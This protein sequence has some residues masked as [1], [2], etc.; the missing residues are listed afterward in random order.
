MLMGLLDTLKGAWKAVTKWFSNDDNEVVSPTNQSQEDWTRKTVTVNTPT[1]NDV[2][3]ELNNE[4]QNQPIVN[5]NPLWQYNDSVQAKQDADRIGNQEMPDPVTETWFL[6]NTSDLITWD[7][8]KAIAK[9]QKDKEKSWFERNIVD[10]VTWFAKWIWDTVDSLSA[11]SDYDANKKDMAMYYDKDSW[12]VYYLDLNTSHWL[13]DWDTG[14]Y[15]WAER[16]FNQAMSEYQ[17]DISNAAS[18][19]ERATALLNFYSKAKDLFR[20]RADD[21]YS[22]WWLFTW[23][24]WKRLGRRK[25]Q[26][27]EETLEKLANNKWV[28]KAWKYVPTFDEFVDY[29]WT[30]Q[31][32]NDIQQ[33]IFGNYW[34]DVEDEEKIDLSQSAQNA[35]KEGFYNTAM[36]WVLDTAK[37]YLNEQDVTNAVLLSADWVTS[38]QNR[39]YNIVAQVYKQEQIVLAKPE[40]ERDDWDKKL[41]EAAN[42]LREMEEEY[43]WDLGNVIR[44]NIKYWS[45]DWVLVDNIDVFEWGKTL[46]QALTENIK[47]TA[48]W[49]WWM[50]ESAIDVFQEVA[51]KALY[52]YNKEK[53]WAWAHMQRAWDLAW[54]FLSELWQQTAFW[55]MAARNVL[56]DVATLNWE[57]LENKFTWKESLTK[58]WNYMDNDNTIGRLL[59]TDKWNNTRTIYSYYLN[60]LEYVPEGVWNLAPDIAIAAATGWAWAWYSAIKWWA[61]VNNAIKAGKWTLLLWR[62]IEAANQW[63]RAA[64]TALRWLEKVSAL[65]KSAEKADPIVKVL[66][67][68]LDAWITNW[69]IDQAIDAQWSQFDTEPYSDTSMILSLAWTWLWEI[70][71]ILWKWWS[72][73][74]RSLTGTN[75][76]LWYIK[77]NPEAIANI[78]KSMNIPVSRLSYNDLYNFLGNFDKMADAAKQVYNNLSK[79]WQVAANQWT[80]KVMYNYLN[81]VYDLN[82]QSM[83]AKNIRS[84]L[85]NG[86]TNPADLAKYVGKIPGTVEFW[87]YVSTIQL[88]NGTRADVLPKSGSYDAWLDSLEGWFASKISWWFTQSDLNQIS[89]IQKYKDIVAEKSKYFREADGKYYLN[90]AW[91]KRFGLDLENQWLS[92]LWVELAEAENVKEIFKEKMKKIRTSEKSITDDTVDAVAESG[93]YSEIVDKIKEIVC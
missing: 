64:T 44:Q 79:E 85:T 83:V 10:N 43:A 35:W 6:K 22:D 28:D 56:W 36:N 4:Q 47:N 71:P 63:W 55:L 8:N 75:D 19:Q 93:A 1:L 89:E 91:L 5:A 13:A 24:D 21:Y 42:K 68:M 52:D 88:K 3:N 41:L 29:L 11:S 70:L 69:I 90:D 9:E 34:L 51:N 38:Q 78:A 62:I 49:E 30:I 57:W 81:Q 80:K 37:T 53:K 25:D 67:Q 2:A 39:I 73:F 76:I 12:D 54:T 82:N 84:I 17:N 14:T 59:Q 26:Y 92:A 72:L 77:N 20:L 23:V 65:A 7:V 16:L 50:T 32:N 33:K 45:K 87:P 15:D 48:W 86:S 66:W 31:E 58:T 27:S 60:W 46:N 61:R 40:G 74:R 18:D